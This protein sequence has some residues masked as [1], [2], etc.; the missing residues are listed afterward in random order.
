LE[1]PIVEPTTLLQLVVEEPAQLSVR[2]QA[3][4]ERLTQVFM[5]ITKRIL[6]QDVQAMH[7]PIETEGFLALFCKE[8]AIMNAA[9]RRVL[10]ERYR[11]GYGEV[12]EAL[13]GISKDELDAHADEGEWSARE[14]VHHLADSE[15]IG[16]IRL[17]RLLAE[18]RPSLEGYD[19]QEFAR[20]LHYGR[21][22][23]SSLAL[24]EAVRRATGELLRRLT[25]AEW[26]R[27]GAHSEIGEYSVETWLQA[28][29]AHCRD[30]ADQI[31]RLR[32]SQT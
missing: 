18:E 32:R 1:Q 5:V 17:R 31:R 15:M 11:E 24:I 20:R 28:Y 14:V 16:A 8:A 21:P 6:D 26:A 19:E 7:P 10:I 29:A 9:E 23:E 13:V 2:V 12:Q 30:H 22:I 25:E 27:S 4:L 3:V